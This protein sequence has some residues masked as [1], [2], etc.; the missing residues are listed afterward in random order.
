MGLPFM[1]RWVFIV[2]TNLWALVSFPS[3]TQ[4]LVD[5]SILW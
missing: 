2:A 3:M 1:W 4:I 5:A